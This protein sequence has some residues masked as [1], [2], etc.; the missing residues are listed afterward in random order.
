MRTLL[1]AAL[2]GLIFL[3]ASAHGEGLPKREAAA[4]P[5]AIEVVTD[6]SGFYAALGVAGNIRQLDVDEPGKTYNIDT[7]HLSGI[8]RAG[9][10]YQRD[11]L[12]AGAF[13]DIT[14]PASGDDRLYALGA[15]AGMSILGVLLQG[16]LGFAWQDSSEEGQEVDLKG[17]FVGGKA[18]LA[19]GGG[20][21]VIAGLRWFA[22]SDDIG[23]AELDSDEFVGTVL[24]GRRF[25]F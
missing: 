12:V 10:R 5:P 11:Q 8:I 15:D 18:T 21:D 20:W 17:P 14:I 23:A 6:W 2:A 7:E 9:Y 16:E 19:L 3:P 13:G 25:K 22:L 24:F 4:P 1:L